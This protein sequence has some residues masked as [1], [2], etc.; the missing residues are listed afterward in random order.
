MKQMTEL[1]ESFFYGFISF[2][3][4]A[5]WQSI[6]SFW[7]EV[8]SIWQSIDSLWR[9]VPTIWQSIDSL[10]REVPAAMVSISLNRAAHTCADQSLSVHNTLTQD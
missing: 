8:P 7:R 4:A 10:W 6:N 3:A 1:S 9:E 5:V 2:L